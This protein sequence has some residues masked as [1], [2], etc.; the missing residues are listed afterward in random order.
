MVNSPF[1]CVDDVIEHNIDNLVKVFYKEGFK[2]IKA[3]DVKY[4]LF[5]RCE[6][7]YIDSDLLYPYEC[8]NEYFGVGRGCGGGGVH[9]PL[10][11]TSLLDMNKRRQGKAQRLINAMRKTF[12][13]IMKQSQELQEEQ[14]GQ[15][16]EFW[17]TFAI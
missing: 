4:E 16:M 2:N 12:W 3:S 7:L 14:T 10:G 17:E 5:D 6:N 1:V 15:K 9:T 8:I 13:S 11:Q